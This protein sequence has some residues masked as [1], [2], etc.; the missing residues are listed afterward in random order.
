MGESDRCWYTKQG[1]L[2]GGE[3]GIF[4]EETMGQGEGMQSIV[5]R[6]LVCL[7]TFSSHFVSRILWVHYEYNVFF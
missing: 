7:V 5:Q 4:V 6:G 1:S 3:E 2:D